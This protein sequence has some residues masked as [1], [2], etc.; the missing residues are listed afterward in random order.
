MKLIH[1]FPVLIIIIPLIFALI[2]P[3]VGR[4]NR[5][6]PWI[7]ASTITFFCFLTS[8]FLLFT[9]LDTGKISYWL[10]GWEPPWGIEYVVDY[11]NA[12]V[13]AV[14]SFIAFIVSLYS[15]RSVEAEI[16]E[17]KQ[18]AF[19]SIYML[20]ITGLLGIVITGDIF[21]MYVFLEITSL[22]G[23][24]MIAMGRKRDALVASYNYLILGTIAATF[25]L[26]GIGYIYMATG[27]LNIADLQERLPALFHSKMV[28]VA[29]AFFTVG[30]SLKLALFPLHTWLPG[31][32][33][34][35]PSV[36]SCIMAATAT[37]VG[38]YA[39]LRI[40]FGVF[41]IEFD[42]HFIPIANILIVVSSM[43]IIAGSAVAITQTNLKSMLAYSSVGQIGYIVLGAVLANQ[44]AMTGSIIHILNHAL[45]KGALFMVVGCIVYKTGIEDIS[46]LRGMCKK[47]PFT[48][49]VFTVAGLSLMGVPLTVGFVSKWY[50]AI[51]ALNAGMGYLI[52][53]IITG[54]LLSAVYIWRIIVNI[55]FPDELPEPE[56]LYTDGG[57]EITDNDT[58]S[59]APWSML[60]PTM[61]LAVLCIYFGISA[62]APLSIAEKAAVMLSQ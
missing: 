46:G 26:I 20:F 28:L 17:D 29:L 12:F 21:N 9:V 18:L 37:K 56:L 58:Y 7:I 19:Y 27:T 62:T 41:K 2:I 33:T 36:V 43:A 10:G 57:T 35:A 61:V 52:P 45:M 48:M 24:A 38:I 8:I 47:M 22:A 54:S 49:A 14:I 5:I 16:N 11:L 40:I 39:M 32:Y 4:L 15:G 25:I 6:L 53:V 31:A 13:L 1:E 42:I 50:I 51:G 34:Y 30:L 55:Y 59:E 60:A 44:T 3:L 23:Y